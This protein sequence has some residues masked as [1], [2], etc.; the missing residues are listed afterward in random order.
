MG[1]V[2]RFIVGKYAGG[3]FPLKPNR[4]IFIGRGSE[5]DMVLDDDMVSRRHA[6]I[7]TMSADVVLTDLGSTNGTT[8]NDKA[9]DTHSLQ[10][11]DRVGIGTS[12][13]EFAETSAD[14]TTPGRRV[15]AGSSADSSSRS[16]A[17]RAGLEGRFAL[18]GTQLPDLI[19][20][21]ARSKKPAVLDLS[22][23]AGERI[24]IY[25]REGKVISAQVREPE[26]LTALIGVEKAFYRALCWAEGDYKVR[27]YAPA[28][29]FKATI[30]L[31]LDDLLRRAAEQVSQHQDHLA[32]LP[33]QTQK[34]TLNSPLEPRLAD[35]SP[36]VLDTLQM[37]INHGSVT[38]TVNHS[39]ATDVETYQDLIYLQ[40]SGYIVLG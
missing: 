26:E 35:L 40:Q 33:E 39:R 14:R 11:G 4:E 36:E 1:Y 2:L 37:V 22:P 28:R 5:F 20:M 24:K 31:S 34:Y 25:F 9:V 30:D 19:R 10:V 16:T 21:V 12:V 23:A 8:V 13:M 3:E 29:V 18:G 32:Y 6:R 38:D 17:H 15:G 7:N 27:G